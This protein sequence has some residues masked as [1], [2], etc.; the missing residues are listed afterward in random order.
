M[1]ITR[2]TI[3]ELTKNGKPL[4]KPIE[5]IICVSEGDVRIVK[6]VFHRMETFAQCQIQ[7]SEEKLEVETLP[8]GQ[9]VSSFVE[10][11]GSFQ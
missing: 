1:E 9:S 2:I 10:L 4:T 5:P 7:Y 11:S 8:A 3:T 6:N